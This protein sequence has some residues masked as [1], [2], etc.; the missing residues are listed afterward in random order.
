MIDEC[1]IEGRL[2]P[3]LVAQSMDRIRPHFSRWVRLLDLLDIQR[4]DPLAAKLI[5]L[6]ARQ[7]GFIRD[8][9]IE[10]RLRDETG[11]RCRT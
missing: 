9:A 6:F 4:D 7:K 8:A 1:Y 3:Y 2:R 5:A 10:H 11:I